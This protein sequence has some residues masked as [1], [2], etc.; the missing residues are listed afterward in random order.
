VDGLL[1][2]PVG[3]APAAREH[4]ADWV[5]VA[6]AAGYHFSLEVDGGTFSLLGDARARPVPVP[7]ADLS[8]PLR[9]L[10]QQLADSVPDE[11]RA[12]LC[13]T[14][15]SLEYGAGTETQTLYALTPEGLVDARQRVVEARTAKPGRPRDARETLKLVG[16]SLL[17]LLALVG[18]TSIF[19][20]WGDLLSSAWRS[21]GNF[22]TASVERDAGP[23]APWIEVS[24][25]EARS[26][27]DG[28]RLLVTLK[29]LQDLPRT[30]QDAAA[31]P[32]PTT[33]E[34]ARAL[35]RG[36]VRVE[37]YGAGADHRRV[38]ISVHEVWVGALRKDG[39]TRVEVP[40]RRGA[41]PVLLRLAW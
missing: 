31:S 9:D 2:G 37:L 7:G 32:D 41:P 5:R 24:K 38:W 3:S 10:L 23:F 19:V 27:R 29:R 40:F 11:V 4:L 1:E 6:D 13:S 14:V 25:I 15:R 16:V 12:G 30:L 22:D 20:D 21:I 33:R 28:S 18:I 26:D 39:T 35:V 17:V 8:E 36:Y 34:A